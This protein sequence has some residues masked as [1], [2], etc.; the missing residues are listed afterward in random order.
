M[1]TETKAKDSAPATSR[2]NKPD[3]GKQS[4]HGMGDR[5]FE[6]AEEIPE[7]FMPDGRPE[8]GKVEERK[9]LVVGPQ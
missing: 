9:E 1:G 8:Q 3:A 4:D 2:E 6:V 7:D 5:L